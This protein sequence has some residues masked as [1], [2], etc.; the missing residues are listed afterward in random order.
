MSDDVSHGAMQR[1]APK[2]STNLI[3]VYP[4]AS[5]RPPVP[6]EVPPEFAE[7]YTEA[8]LVISD[9]PKASAALSR[10]CLQHIL[11]KKAGVKNPNDLAKAIDEVVNDPSMPSDICTSLDAVRH[12][13][14]FSAHPN[15]S[16]NTGEIVAVEAGEAK[17]CLEVIEILFNFYFVR[18]ADIKRRTL[19][20]NQKLNETGKPPM[21]V[22]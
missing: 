7:D 21:P 13:G 9:S 10:R 6:T 8:C 12:I 1:S 15:K 18:P 19:A 22:T 4:K 3:M 17:W 20:L 11:R 5:G 16:T 2:G 14:N